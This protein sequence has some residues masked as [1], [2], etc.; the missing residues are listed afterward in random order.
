MDSNCKFVILNLDYQPHI[1]T[2]R[3]LFIDAA[4]VSID[5]RLPYMYFMMYI[6]VIMI[7]T[8]KAFYFFLK[9]VLFVIM[10]AYINA[11]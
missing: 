2:V 4:F 5:D 6:I 11:A 1:I 7:S 9:N 3:Y 8:I 10:E